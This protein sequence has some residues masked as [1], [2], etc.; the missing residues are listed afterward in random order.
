MKKQM[1]T[2]I[3]AST[4]AISL[5]GCG[6]KDNDTAVTPTNSGAAVDAA[7]T[8]ASQSAV[9]PG[10]D[11]TSVTV[12]VGTQ[13]AASPASAADVITISIPESMVNKS[14]ANPQES[15]IQ[16]GYQNAVLGSD[17]SLTITMTQ[18]DQATL[19]SKITTAI[20]TAFQQLVNGT[21]TPYI[22]NIT[23]DADFTTITVFVDKDSYTS[24]FID[25]TPASVGEY[26]AFYQIYKGVTPNITIKIVDNLTSNTLETIPYSI[27]GT[28]AST[29]TANDSTT[30]ASS[31]TASSAT[32]SSASSSGTSTTTDTSDMAVSSATEPKPLTKGETK[33]YV[34]TE[35]TKLY[36]ETD[37]ESKVLADI[38]QGTTFSSSESSEY[39]YKTTI[40]GETGFLRKKF[41]KAN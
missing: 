26:A 31:T 22:T 4:I 32:A 36:T 38:K 8:V 29:T 19:L 7:A 13:Q 3:L 20:D 16:K 10:A 12:G 28:S 33:K 35:D 21:F 41:T 39:F 5:A 17:N 27:S 9:A 23:H 6:N 1:F 34:T 11:L 18:A 30:A 40:N 24:T 37:K 25:M 15:A 14:I 2:F